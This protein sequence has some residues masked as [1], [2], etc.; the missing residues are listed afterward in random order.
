MHA[1]ARTHTVNLTRIN[2]CMRRESL[3]REFLSLNFALAAD[4]DDLMNFDAKLD[5]VI[6]KVK[7]MEAELD[8]ITSSVNRKLQ[9]SQDVRRGMILGGSSSRFFKSEQTVITLRKSAKMLQ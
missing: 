1:H 8:K 7:N 3:R 2:M 6:R 9:E 4:M 5:L